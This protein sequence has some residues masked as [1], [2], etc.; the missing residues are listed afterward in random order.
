[1]AERFTSDLLFIIFVLIIAAILG[2]LI[3]YFIRKSMKCKKCEEWEEEN[4]SLKLKINRTEESEALLIEKNKKLQDQINDQKQIIEKLSSGS[5]T[6][7]N[8]EEQGELIEVVSQKKQ[9]VPVAEPR[10]DDLRIVLGIGP[11]IS[12]IL[13]NRGIVTWKQ[14]S[15][16]DPVLINQYLLE[17]GGERYRIH[18]PSTW[19]Y[20]AKLADEGKWEEL[21]DFQGKIEL[22]TD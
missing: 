15:E 19:P 9:D 1:M 12:G 4:T 13:N 20:Q 5:N 7:D 14:L 10:K 3:G 16:T 11:K 18:N 2:Y 21:K 6:G 8:K 17:D 22:K